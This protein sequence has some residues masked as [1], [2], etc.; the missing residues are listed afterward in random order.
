MFFDLNKETL[1]EAL[2]QTKRNMNI[3]N[4]GKQ[5]EGPGVLAECTG[6]V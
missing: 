6:G 4:A 2:M 1:T 3:F 5:N